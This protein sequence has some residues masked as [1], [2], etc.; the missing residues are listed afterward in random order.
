MK[1]AG[2][3]QSAAGPDPSDLPRPLL[4]D[5]FVGL[6]SLGVYLATLAPTITTGDSGDLIAAAARF[7][8]AHP[9]GYPLYLLLGRV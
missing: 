5:G 7:E 3:P 2:T 6:A 9:T 8:V 1:T 4:A